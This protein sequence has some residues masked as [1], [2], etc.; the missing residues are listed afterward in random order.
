MSESPVYG[1]TR[2]RCPTACYGEIERA[3][4]ADDLRRAPTVDAMRKVLGRGSPNHL[5][6]SIK[7][8]CLL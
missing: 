7:K 4:R 8:C 3:A 5:T 6:E 2:E 1:V